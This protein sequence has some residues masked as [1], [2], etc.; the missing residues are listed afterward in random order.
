MEGVG[1]ISAERHSAALYMHDGKYGH[2]VADH[3][4]AVTETNGVFK[5]QRASRA[6]LVPLTVTG[7]ELHL[8]GQHEDP[9]AQ[10]RR[11]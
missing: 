6:N 4:A 3:A 1:G 11:S 2:V 9:H 8:P 7:L 5:E 10:R